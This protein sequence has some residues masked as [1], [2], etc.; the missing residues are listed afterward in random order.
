MLESSLPKHICGC[1][2]KP[3]RHLLPA[4]KI[5]R[6]TRG[7][8]GAGRSA[9][10]VS[11]STPTGT[12]GCALPYTMK[13]VRALHL[14]SLDR[15]E[16]GWMAH[17]WRANFCTDKDIDFSKK[18]WLQNRVTDLARANGC[19]LPCTTTTACAQVKCN[20]N[21]LDR[22]ESLFEIKALDPERVQ[23]PCSGSY[24]ISEHWHSQP[25]Q[26]RH[27]TEQQYQNT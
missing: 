3:I 4:N 20:T 7:L 25:A 13:S 17:V 27:Q 15:G 16:K 1:G 18:P 14:R 26:V 23:L 11:T 9:L 21:T 5:S 8:G 6:E 19:G 22:C 2:M 24:T 12:N 10:H